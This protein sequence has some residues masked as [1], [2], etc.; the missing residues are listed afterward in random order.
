MTNNQKMKRTFDLNFCEQRSEGDN[1]KILEGYAVVFDSPTVL[2]EVDGVE[3]K[4]IISRNAFKGTDLKDVCLKYNHNDSALILART[5]NKSLTIE[6]DDK[7]LKFRAVLPDTTGANDVYELVKCG[8]LDKCSFAFRCEASDYD[9]ET[10][11]RNITK[12]KRLY[13]VSVV[14]VPAYDDTNV[15]ARSYFDGIAKA[16]CAMERAQRVKRM[17]CES[18]L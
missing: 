11:T 6:I 12:I 2:Y 4:E 16:Q 8:L 1:T 15:E 5:R 9:K 17:I 13:D 18:Y 7:G 10:H 14:D 3:Y